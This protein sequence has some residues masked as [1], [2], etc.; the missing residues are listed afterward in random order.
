MEMEEDLKNG[1]TSKKLLD[2]AVPQNSFIKMQD[3]R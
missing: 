1:I 2:L 3:I